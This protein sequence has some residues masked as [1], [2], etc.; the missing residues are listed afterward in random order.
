MAA[1]AETAVAGGAAAAGGAGEAE[2]VRRFAK[3]D[4][5]DLVYNQFKS[6]FLKE[7]CAECGKPATKRYSKTMSFVVAQMLDAYWCNEC[8]RV[9]CDACRYQHRCERL[10]QQ[11]ERNK[12][13]TKEQLAAQ[14]AEAEALKQAAEDAKKAEARRKAEAEEQQR[15]VR[16]DRRA[17]LARKA[18]CVED[19]LQGFL[20][21]AEAN[22]ARG[23]RAR[24]ELFDMYGRSKRLSLTLYNE[25][26][27]P[28]GNELAED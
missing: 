12:H 5:E 23:P 24:D 11:K 26:E 17:L 9:L 8:G 14:L 2:T 13:L 25:Y 6:A 27:H 3:A 22:A 10:D 28:S 16:K 15:L 20:R 19:F 7:R 4:I 1:A 18:K 21:D